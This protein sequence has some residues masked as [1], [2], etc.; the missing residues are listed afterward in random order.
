[1]GWCFLSCK[2]KLH[3]HLILQSPQHC[4]DCCFNLSQ[5]NIRLMV[6]HVTFHIEHMLHTYLIV[7]LRTRRPPK[8]PLAPYFK[9]WGNKYAQARG[10]SCMLKWH[11]MHN[12]SVLL[13]VA[14]TKD[15]LVMLS[16]T[17]V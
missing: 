5:L 4:Q 6:L 3:W 2:G 9:A 17:A 15:C 14:A 16:S 12:A 8:R 11:N 1:M 13:A 7:L 10:L